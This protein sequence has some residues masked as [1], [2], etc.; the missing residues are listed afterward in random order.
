M[1]FTRLGYDGVSRFNQDTEATAFYPGSLTNRAYSPVRSY[2][3]AL[4]PGVVN[5]CTN[6]EFPAPPT[7]CMAVGTLDSFGGRAEVPVKKPKPGLLLKLPTFGTT[8]LY[9]I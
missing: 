1:W 5:M 9:N 7:S 6:C 8:F 4:K 2:A 3:T